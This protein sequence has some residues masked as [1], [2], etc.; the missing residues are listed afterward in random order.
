MGKLAILTHC[1]NMFLKKRKALGCFRQMTEG[2]F[3]VITELRV[4]VGV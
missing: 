2:H 1:K 3:I 4:D